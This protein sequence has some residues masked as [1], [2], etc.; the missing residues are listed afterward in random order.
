MNSQT[1]ELINEMSR[2]PGGGNHIGALKVAT[3][4]FKIYG[5]DGLRKL[6]DKTNGYLDIWDK[7]IN[8]GEDIVTM[9]TNL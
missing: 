1:D 3:E 4:V 5:E 9:Y 6:K 8:A 2:I 7:F